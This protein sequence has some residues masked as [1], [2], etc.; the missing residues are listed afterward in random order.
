MTVQRS[1]AGRH[2]ILLP[3][4]SGPLSSFPCSPASLFSIGTGTREG[5]K[6]G[7]QSV[8][9]EAVIQEPVRHLSD[10]QLSPRLSRASI[11]PPLLR[12][13]PLARPP[14]RPAPARHGE[15]EKAMG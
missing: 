15:R 7:S 8:L 1:P 4:P 13:S 5:Q 6:K 2:T 14:T 11:H 9:R 3:P 12:T 10:P